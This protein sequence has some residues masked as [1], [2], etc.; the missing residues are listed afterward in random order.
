M[1]FVSF[2]VN[3]IRARQHQLSAIVA[4][5]QPD[6]LAAAY[7]VAA[8]RATGLPV[9]RW[10]GSRGGPDGATEVEVADL[11]G[12]MDEVASIARDLAGA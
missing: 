7:A 3:G 11:T 10:P 2:N 8:Q 1:R 12:A 6:I 5:Y 9:R 4:K